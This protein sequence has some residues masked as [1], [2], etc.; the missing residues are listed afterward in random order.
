[1]EPL[2]DTIV[3]VA[4]GGVPAAVAVLRLSGPRAT[5]IGERV[6]AGLSETFKPRNVYVRWLTDRNTG[7]R[8]DQGLVI[9][10]R[11]PHSY[12][13]QDVVEIHCHGGLGV[14]DR[15]LSLLIDEGARPA[16]PGEFTL[17]AFLAGKLDLSQAEAVGRL[18]E[19]RTQ[20]AVRYAAA[21]LAG[22]LADR[23]RDIASLVE[24][25]RIVL[26]AEL[27]FPDEDL[28]LDGDALAGMVDRAK[29][30]LEA[31]LREA[32][33]ARLVFEGVRVA[34]V[35]RPN[36]GKSSLFNRLLGRQRAV[37][38]E[39]AGTT[40]DYL[41]ER[42]EMGGLVV[43]LLDT[44]GQRGTEDEVEQEAVKL[45]LDAVAGADVVMVVVD[46]TR[47]PDRED[48]A[49]W[50]RWAGRPRL[51]VV[52]KRD[53]A[54]GSWWD[55]WAQ[56]DVVWVSARTGEG[57]DLLRQ[58]IAGLVGAESGP[59]GLVVEARQRGELGRALGL[60]ESAERALEAG[61]MLDAAA[62]ELQ[63]AQAALGRVL[64]EGVGQDVLD[65][66]FGRFCIGK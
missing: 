55:G 17:R 18:V 13:G 63:G 50:S 57:M 10:F 48:G 58:K 3:A 62:S 36:V 49:V 45:G 2:D 42:L 44:A 46:A 30:G 38:H 39:R 15:L 19:A 40:R 51:L 31:L 59:A 56:G 64:G 28:D 25:V 35:G 32:A 12:T 1:M 14:V 65:G 43:E 60:L 52:N 27:E 47:E 20:Q 5:R 37:V 54:A 8:I 33:D 9:L 24:E 6:V 22:G 34:L 21:N 16:G 41:A 66:V 11:G 61:G 23:V 29:A 4:T 53:L 7:E 26:E